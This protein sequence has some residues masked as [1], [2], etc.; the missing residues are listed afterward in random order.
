[1]YIVLRPGDDGFDCFD[2]QLK[3]EAFIVETMNG[4]R[5]LNEKDFRVFSA[6]EIYI[7]KKN[8][9]SSI[10]LTEDGPVCFATPKPDI[11]L[12]TKDEIIGELNRLRNEETSL[13]MRLDRLG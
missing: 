1:M 8:I 3:A 10:E 11:P 4:P 12:I 7:G 9:V 13:R 2:D 5:G 6:R